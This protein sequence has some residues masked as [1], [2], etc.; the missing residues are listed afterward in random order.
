MLLTLKLK[1]QEVPTNA[2]NNNIFLPLSL[3]IGQLTLLLKD[4]TQ[5]FNYINFYKFTTYVFI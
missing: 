2:P 1:Y 5:H 4:T 3:T